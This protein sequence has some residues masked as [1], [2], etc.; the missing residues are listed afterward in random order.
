MRLERIRRG[1]HPNIS[2][3]Q[4]REIM[5]MPWASRYGLAQGIPPAY[6]EYIGRQLM[7]QLADGRKE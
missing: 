4:K 7:L 5:E 3:D 2:V 6:T 1:L